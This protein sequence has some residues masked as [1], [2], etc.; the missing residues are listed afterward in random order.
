MGEKHVI[1]LGAGASAS[2]GY[3]LVND[4]RLLMS[5][6]A[7][8]KKSVQDAVNADIENPVEANNSD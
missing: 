2:S 5:S 7:H 3:P 1:F 8:F 4:L 6:R